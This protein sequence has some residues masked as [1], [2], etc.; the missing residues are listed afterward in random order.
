MSKITELCPPSSF[1]FP[2]RYRDL[3]SPTNTF[4]LALCVCDFFMSAI[5]SPIPAYYAFK[6]TFIK[7]KLVCDIDAFAV[8]FLGLTSLYLLAAIS[9]DRYLVIVKP[10]SDFVVTQRAANLAVSVCVILGFFW[11]LMPLVGWN[12]YTLEGIGIACSVNWYSQDA[13]HKTF[14]IFVF[15]F[16][17]I[18]PFV[19]MLFCYLKIARTVKQIFSDTGVTTSRKHALI[20]NRLLQT[21]IIMIAVF[22]VSW[23]PYVVISFS[24][25]FGT[26]FTMSRMV[27]TIP[28]L[29]AKASCVWN[30]IIYVAMNANFRTGFISLIPLWRSLLPSGTASSRSGSH[31][32]GGPATTGRAGGA[33]SNMPLSVAYTQTEPGMR[34]CGQWTGK[35]AVGTGAEPRLL[36]E[37]EERRSTQPCVLHMPGA[38]GKITSYTSGAEGI[39]GQYGSGEPFLTGAAD[40]ESKQEQ[41]QRAMSPA[42][43]RNEDDKSNNAGS[44]YEISHSSYPQWGTVVQRDRILD[45]AVSSHDMASSHHVFVVRSVADTSIPNERSSIIRTANSYTHQHIY[46][47]DRHLLD[48][49]RSCV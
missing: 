18:L 36:P 39:S 7:S 21:I 1:P 42:E 28:A 38:G 19:V 37:R 35:V 34:P 27:A 20:E 43:E 25:A 13:G 6:E 10:Y 29:I 2:D 49:Q 41:Q 31:P 24:E 40:K 15:I 30:P 8:Y 47:D 16:C 14:I 48:S 5:G 33:A 45:S 32:T 12:E 22:L 46:T 44:T 23:L 11:A 9:V 4:I 3:R 26:G 17:F